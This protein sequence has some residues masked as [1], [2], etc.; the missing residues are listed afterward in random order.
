MIPAAAPPPSSSTSAPERGGVRSR[1]RWI[2]PCVLAAMIVVASGRSQV[3]A[4]EVVNI[5]KLIHFSVFGLLATLVVRAPGI[6]A[7]WMAVLLVSLFGI[8][9]EIRQSFTPG[10]SVEFADWLA[11]T[12]GAAVAVAAYTFWAG[13]RGLLET[14]LRR[15]RR[16]SVSS[17][18]SVSASTSSRIVPVA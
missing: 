18:V 2:Y 9:D 17:S 7:A 16:N 8:S 10:R 3:A 13:Y 5:D 1:L 6:R 14:M 15:K 4:P 11:D 12:A